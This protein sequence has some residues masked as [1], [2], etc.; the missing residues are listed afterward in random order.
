MNQVTP[1]GYIDEDDWWSN[2]TNAYDDNINTSADTDYIDAGTQS[3]HLELNIALPV[4]CDRIRAAALAFYN[5][6]RAWLSMG[7]EVYYN[8]GWHFA[9]NLIL[10]GQLRELLLNGIYVVGKM[11]FRGSASE[12]YPEGGYFSLY[13]A[14]FGQVSIRPLVNGSLAESVLLEKGL[15]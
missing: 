13:E 15:V 8:D 5:E 10:D 14:D 12:D 3:G 1:T 6:G 9:G 4:S 11:R 2:E 7:A